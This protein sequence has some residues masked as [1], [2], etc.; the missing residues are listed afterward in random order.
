MVFIADTDRALLRLFLWISTDPI[1][2]FRPLGIAEGSCGLLVL[3]W[4][5]ILSAPIQ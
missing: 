4:L 1:L 5:G 2:P 3:R